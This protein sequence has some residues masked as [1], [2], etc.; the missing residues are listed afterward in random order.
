MLTILKSWLNRLCATC[1]DRFEL[2]MEAFGFPSKASSDKARTGMVWRRSGPSWPTPPQS[3][4][5]AIFLVM[6]LNL[7]V[8]FFFALNRQHLNAA[9]VG[10]LTKKR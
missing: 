9:F 5:R 10:L 6:N 2:Y 8:R 1:H 7:L 3:W 4:I